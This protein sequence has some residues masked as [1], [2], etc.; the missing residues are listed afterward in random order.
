[1]HSLAWN[2]EEVPRDFWNFLKEDQVEARP[3]QKYAGGEQVF[4]NE[5]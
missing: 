1:M 3:F 4:G 2:T 5:M